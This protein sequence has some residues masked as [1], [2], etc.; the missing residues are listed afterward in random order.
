MWHFYL[1]F[2]CA[3]A[4]KIEGID[5]CDILK[6]KLS[7]F[8]FTHKILIKDHN[9]SLKGFGINPLEIRTRWKTRILSFEIFNKL[10][11]FS[12]FGGKK[13]L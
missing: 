4:F 3:N 12:I 5:A 8:F 11:Q 9:P 2:E 7:H 10:S 6:W 13:K 1:E